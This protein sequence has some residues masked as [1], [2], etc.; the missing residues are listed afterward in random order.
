M[1]Y[2][3]R[4]AQIVAPIAALSIAVGC[5]RED[6]SASPER[7]APA[8]GHTHSGESHEHHAGDGHDHEHDRKGHEEPGA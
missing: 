1:N 5:S 3:R 8:D 7:H 4:L 6:S 2:L